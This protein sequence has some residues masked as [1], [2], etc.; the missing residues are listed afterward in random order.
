MPM[1][2]TFRSWP[3]GGGTE[4]PPA[5]ATGSDGQCALTVRLVQL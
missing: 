4:L 1:T 5:A 2:V 3:S